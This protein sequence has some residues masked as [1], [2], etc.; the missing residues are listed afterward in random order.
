M[1]KT[2]N[3]KSL[4]KSLDATFVTTNIIIASLLIAAPFLYYQV[5]IEGQYYNLVK[6]IE[7]QEE[8]SARDVGV[9]VYE[10]GYDI[11]NESDSLNDNL[12]FCQATDVYQYRENLQTSRKVIVEFDNECS[13]MVISLNFIL[14]HGFTNFYVLIT[15][16]MTILV[17]VGNILSFRKIKA[18]IIFAF[19]NVKAE[20][21][22]IRLTGNNEDYQKIDSYY[23]EFQIIIN[24]ID[25]LN[26]QINE[27]ISERHTLVSTLNHELKSPINKINSL[28]QAY[29]MGMPGYDDPKQMTKVIEGELET[30]IN[31]VNFSLDVFVK[32]DI[33]EMKEI[34]LTEI[35][36]DL[37]DQRIER[38]A[39]RNIE[40]N[41]QFK[42]EIYVVSDKRI[43]ELVFSNL[44]E[45]ISKYAAENS[46]FNVLLDEKQVLFENKI[47]EVRD[48]GTQQGLK[49][50]M[51]LIK[52]AGFDLTYREVGDKFSVLITFEDE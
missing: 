24:N 35:I 19:K 38:L 40:S 42:D 25:E 43:I 28:I 23:G 46:T 30:L 4:M 3:K 18:N 20:I 13:N 47:A 10:H 31:I 6:Y 44:I 8:I 34:N 17:L 1:M 21:D 2:L 9:Y 48:V 36:D 16:F 33:Q 45:N 51:Q 29:D 22:E 39:V 50:S 12:A 49:L 7:S 14:L 26:T 27:Y 11:L 15:F 5:F 41:F 32:T 52:T 37:I